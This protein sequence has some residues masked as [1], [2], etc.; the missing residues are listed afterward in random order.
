[1]LRRVLTA[2]YDWTLGAVQ[3]F[4][5]GPTDA[6]R[7]STFRRWFTLALLVYLADRSMHPFEW[8][9]EEGFHPSTSARSIYYPRQLPLLP[10]WAV[11]PFLVAMFTSVILLLI[12]WHTRIMTWIV[13]LFVVY[14]SNVDI[15]SSFTINKLFTVGYFILAVS[16]PVVTTEKD[17]K[18]IKLQ[19]VWPIRVFQATLL[20]QYFTAGYCKVFHGNW[21]DL[22]KLK[23]RS[24]D[25]HGQLVMQYDL[26]KFFDTGWL[27]SGDIL[28]SQAQGLYCTELCAWLLRILPRDAWTWMQHS[29]LA[30]EMLGPLLFLIPSFWLP[31]GRICWALH[32]P[33]YAK[34]LGIKR[35]WLIS[36]SVVGMLWGF[37][38]HLVIALT[39]YKLFYF[40]FQMVTFYLLWFSP[41]VLHRMNAWFGR[42]LS[43]RF[44]AKGSE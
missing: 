10:T 44:G 18:Q 40:S 7:L 36:P 26:W 43:Y 20:C 22:D 19:S 24:V 16:P 32:M 29:S 23:V 34:S 8:L 3:R 42:V 15:A 14:A 38:F 6:V 2:T 27:G 39:M 21:L 33:N 41:A 9:T 13:W 1:M 35:R 31:I 28:W 25:E 30:F 17:G 11:A 37:G 12:E 4:L 5:F